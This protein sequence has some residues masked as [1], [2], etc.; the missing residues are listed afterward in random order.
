MTYRNPIIE[1]AMRNGVQLDRDRYSG[2]RISSD[3]PVSCNYGDSHGIHTAKFVQLIQAPDP[4]T[5]NQ[6]VQGS[7]P[8]APT[9]KI[10]GL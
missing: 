6:R 4:I 2:V 7:S 5:L 9:N 10:N 1:W 8:C 3:A